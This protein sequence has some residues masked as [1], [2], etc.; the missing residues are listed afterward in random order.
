MPC[1]VLVC[2][3]MLEDVSCGCGKDATVS[4]KGQIIGLHQAKINKKIIELSPKRIKRW[5]DNSLWL[6]CYIYRTKGFLL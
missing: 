4:Q 2:T 1:V 5:Q 3:A 6:I